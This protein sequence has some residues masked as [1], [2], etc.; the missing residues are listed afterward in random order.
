MINNVNYSIQ[1]S[2]GRKPFIVHVDRLRKYE[3]EITEK[4]GSWKASVFGKRLSNES[5]LI[6]CSSA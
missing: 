3:G 1:L 4:M 5:D 6:E 2:K